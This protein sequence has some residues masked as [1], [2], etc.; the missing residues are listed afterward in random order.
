MSGTTTTSRRGQGVGSE[1]DAS[2]FTDLVLQH[3]ALI[4]DLEAV[5]AALRDGLLLDGTLTISA[6]AE[7]FKTTSTAVYTIAGV[8]YTKAA[9]DNLV[10]S[11]ADTINT[12]A[13][14]G[15][16]WGVWLVQINAAGTVST[17]SPSADQ[18]YASE[19]AAIAALP[20]PDSGK[21]GL[22]YITVE[23]LTDADWVATTDDL[24]AASDAQA[25]NFYDIAVKT[26]PLAV[27]LTAA[28]IG[29]SSGV[30]IA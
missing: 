11:A 1:Q 30:A 22:G 7:K 21:V 24:T 13:A 5:S 15:D 14:L 17:K 25:A 29:D 20:S 19:A 18:V 9:T 23:A 28:K 26:I 16:F 8:T 27:D 10:F 12:G 4:D 2:V 6:T 3:N